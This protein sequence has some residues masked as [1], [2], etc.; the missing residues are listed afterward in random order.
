MAAKA[1]PVEHRTSR[2]EFLKLAGA[3]AAA[4]GAQVALPATAAASATPDELAA[5][6][7]DDPGLLIDLT[8]CIGCGSCA[9]ACKL[10]NRLEY[11]GDQP[12]LG[13]R[14]E[15]ASSN[16]T[17]VRTERDSEGAPVYVKQQCMHCLEPA[18]VSA[19]PVRALTKAPVGAVTY[20]VD[21][22]IGCRYCLMACPF[23]V[24]TF[25]WDRAISSVSKCDLCPERT[26]R[27]EP[28]A[29]ASAC[30][31]GAIAFGRRGDLLEEAHRRIDE[32]PGKY[33]EHVYGENEAGGTSVLYLSDVPFEDLGFPEGLPEEPLPAYTWQITRL[34]PAVASG[35][36]A[37]LV[38]LYARR[39]KI[40]L[41]ADEVPETPADAG[42]READEAGDGT[43]REG[44]D[45]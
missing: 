4:V 5:R 19:C 38:V 35:L 2:R 7:A 18:C 34:I 42:L 13:P 11:R 21:R 41:E 36:A 40:L 3:G 24:P 44:S 20:D 45:R 16:W 26:S 15:L 32:E 17:V 12:T 39:R 37:A 30:P 23:G 43:E 10:D 33:V 29:C 25:E 8:R 22:C 6:H 14:V 9:T 31:T 27:G 28:T 1:G